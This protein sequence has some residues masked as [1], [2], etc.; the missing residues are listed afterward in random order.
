MIDRLQILTAELDIRGCQHLGETRE[1]IQRCAHLVG[2]LL[3]ELRFHP[4]RLFCLLLSYQ[5]FAVGGIEL[6]IGL[7][8]GDGVDA[9]EEHDEYKADT[10]THLT[11]MGELCPLLGDL[12]F[13]SLGI[14]DG[15]KDGGITQLLT[16]QCRVVSLS[17][18]DGDIQRTVLSA[19]QE[20]GTVFGQHVT[21]DILK[22]GLRTAL[23]HEL[24]EA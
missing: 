23:L 17:D 11:L 7:A 3:D 20:V 15:G 14:E 4:G 13:L 10:N 8:T 18:L 24:V 21:S 6:M 22:V 16:D 5:E 2:D 1:H 9:E 19:C 12:T